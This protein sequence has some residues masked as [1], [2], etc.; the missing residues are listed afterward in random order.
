MKK[1]KILL[2]CLLLNSVLLFSQNIINSIE[3]SGNKNVSKEKILLLMKMKP[4]GQFNEGILR[5]DI[6]RIAESGFFSSVSYNIESGEKGT[7]IKIIVV[8][9][10]VV[11]NIY[12][13]GNKVFKTKDLIEF[14]GVN[15]GDILNEIELLSGIERIKE[16]YKEKQFYFTEVDYDTLEKE[17]GVVLN[18]LINEQGRRYVSRIVFKGNKAFSDS[19]L[20]GLMKI[21]QRNMPFI[22]GSFKPDVFEKDIK[23][24][25]NFYKEK[26]FLTAK[27]EGVTSI[28]TKSKGIKIEISV[29]EGQKY[30]V[31]DIKFEGNL[32]V[33]E[34]E[35][36]NKLS[37]KKKGDVFNRKLA[38]ENVRNLSGFYINR[39][40]LK[41]KVSEI[42]VTGEKPDIINIIYSIEPGEVYTAGEVII[43]GNYKTKDKVIRREVKIFPG[44]KITSEKLQ[45][46]FNNL[47]DLNYFDKINIYPE[48]TGT[49][50]ADIVV[51]VE[52]KA[53][54]GMFLI[55]GGYSSVED[56][57]GMISI[58][59]SNF[60]ITNPP[61][62]T[63]GGQQLSLMAQFGTQTNSY[64]ISF[65][66]PYFLDKPVWF[67]T[68]LYRTRRLFSDYTDERTGGA[69]RLG[70]RWEKASL[71]LT[72]RI[73][74]ITLS[75]IDIPSLKGQEGDYRKNSITGTFLYSA[76]DRKRAP[77]RGIRSEVSLEYAGDVL[78]GDV[79]FLK[80]VLENDIYYPLGRWTFHSRTY[81]GAVEEIGDTKEIPIYERFF[82]GGIGTVRGYEERSLGPKDG[83]Y[84]LG[85][86]AVFAQNLELIYPLYQDILKGVLFFDAGNVW[87]D[88]DSID[89]LRKG[90]GAGIKVVIPFLNAPVEI[91]YGYALDRKDGEPEGRVHIGMWFGF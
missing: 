87:E 82:G 43:R 64:K 34:K 77:N 79:N 7:D 42:P 29:S 81:A 88:W 8:E 68:D 6:K 47:F 11:K 54:T 30:Y 38:D 15:K 73:E 26:G 2:L 49:N 74:G 37:L 61:K 56:V 69:L 25:E 85:G 72:G 20:R 50:T 86:Q 89:E 59:Q 13:K 23:V 10:P 62:F 21:K 60:D 53:K 35:L 52:E 45:K 51:D 24:I 80:P 58:S 22:R 32:L 44:D 78:G 16:K 90:I 5:E 63:G 84:P 14:L 65:T 40:Y 76:L 31:G 57:V 48:F 41:V 3:V 36:R 4:G 71:G 75:D 9:N 70:R 46:S 33:D 12:F 18:V 28:D 19:R 67:G 83:D 55:G 66:E 1:A 39:G 27:V 17:D 91:Y